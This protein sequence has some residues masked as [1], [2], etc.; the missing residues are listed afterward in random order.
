MPGA[1]TKKTKQRRC[2]EREREREKILNEEIMAILAVRE[3]NACIL[4]FFIPYFLLLSY[5]RKD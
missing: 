5:F 4:F 1:K 3:R 2:R